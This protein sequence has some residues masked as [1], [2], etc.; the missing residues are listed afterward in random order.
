MWTLQVTILTVGTAILNAAIV[1]SVLGVFAVIG[2]A[3]RMY[4][5]LD[6]P[7]VK[8]ASPTFMLLILAGTV[9]VFISIPLMSMDRVNSGSVGAATQACRSMQ[10]LLSLG[11]MCVARTSLL[12]NLIR[13]ADLCA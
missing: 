8:A 4:S 11:V 5:R 10:F 7:V 3:F 13:I 1:V 6:E 9:L 12:Y 2:V